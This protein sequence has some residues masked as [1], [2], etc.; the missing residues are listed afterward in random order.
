MN[1]TEMHRTEMNKRVEKRE[2]NR[3]HKLIQMSMYIISASTRHGCRQCISMQCS[4]SAWVKLK[5]IPGTF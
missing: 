1:K 5:I 3:L 4:P 2:K